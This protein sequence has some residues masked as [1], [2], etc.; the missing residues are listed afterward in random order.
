M[1]VNLVFWIEG[2]GLGLFTISYKSLTVATKYPPPG[3]ENSMTIFM[4]QDEHG[5]RT[6][7][8]IIANGLGLKWLKTQDST[9]NPIKT[10]IFMMG[11]LVITEKI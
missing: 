1:K 4:G 2:R 9:Q 6:K 7:Q 5:H 8:R 11:G 3:G 10:Y